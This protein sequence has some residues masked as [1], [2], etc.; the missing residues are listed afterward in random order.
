LSLQQASEQIQLDIRKQECE[1]LRT[2][3]SSL[4]A[5][6]KELLPYE[7]IYRVTKAQQN[8]AGGDVAEVTGLAAAKR[9]ST[10]RGGA[11]RRRA[12]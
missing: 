11:N 8:E 2:E 3:I 4:N 9:A 7:R 12:V 10:R 6:I 5:R 1:E